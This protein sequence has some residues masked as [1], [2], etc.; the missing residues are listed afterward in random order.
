MVYLKVDFQTRCCS[1]PAGP[2]KAFPTAEAWGPNG[3]PFLQKRSSV[4]SLSGE[5]LAHCPGTQDWNSWRMPGDSGGSQSGATRKDL[6]AKSSGLHHSSWSCRNAPFSR[7]KAV[8]AAPGLGCSEPLT[9]GELEGRDPHN[10]VV[11]TSYLCL[12]GPVQSR[13]ERS[14]VQES[15]R[16][17]RQ[18][19][20][21]IPG[22][23]PN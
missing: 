2:S 20:E 15:L 19:Q 18:G 14:L 21:V 13:N 23:G 12:Q 22:W 7:E 9:S 6:P 10:S 11:Q 4:G 16:I 3:C 8:I 5:G 1:R 17:L